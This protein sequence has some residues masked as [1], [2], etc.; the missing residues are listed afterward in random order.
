MIQNQTD[1]SI[2]FAVDDVTPGDV[3]LEECK[4]HQAVRW[5]VE[6]NIESCFDYHGQV[7]KE[8]YHG[9][10]AAVHT[11]FSEHRPLVLSPDHVWLTISQGIAHH[12]VLNA[13]RLRDRFVAHPDRLT[14]KFETRDWVRGTP[15]NPWP[16]AFA[17]WSSSIREHVGAKTH[18]ILRCDFSTTGPIEAAA[19][20]IVIMDVFERYFHFAVCCIC[21]I[22]TVTLQGTSA[23]WDRL[24][25]K[26]RQLEVFDIKWWL[27]HLIP[28]CEQFARAARGD[29]DLKHWRSICK[30]RE[31]YGGDVINGWV[32]KLFPYL[33]AYSGG[34]CTRRNPIF[35][36]G[37]GF[38][39]LVAP[40]GLSM[41]P[42]TWKDPAGERAMEAIGGFV[43][44]SQDPTTLALR[45]KIG[46]A[47][48][49]VSRMQSLISRIERE[50]LSKPPN[51]KLLHGRQFDPGSFGDRIPEDLGEFYS[52]SNGADLFVSDG[53]P[54]VE[55]FPWQSM[56]AA[57]VDVPGQT[58]RFTRF[59]FARTTNGQ[60]IST[61]ADGGSSNSIR[62][63]RSVRPHH[64]D[65]IIACD[66]EAF[67]EGLLDGRGKIYW[68]Q[69]DFVPLTEDQACQLQHEKRFGWL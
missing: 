60:L 32:A 65:P 21:G 67:L 61:D 38:Q 57:L 9:L 17:S 62:A 14:L 36:S 42:F 52:R 66:V 37:E 43:G 10:L 24:L 7:L 1:T 22:P 55:I 25:E 39:S 2:T 44:V 8:A 54:L 63:C 68:E 16:E 40:S 11:A 50:H 59:I 49:E 53:H 30:L 4:S 26:A 12:M 69:P 64:D 19:S 34:P 15:E 13:D 27:K 47:V 56:K 23:D 18:D 6:S 20:D 48:R 3:A 35:S 51:R 33:R 41:V 45:P 29:I 28:I 31:D 58:S 5:L 46:W